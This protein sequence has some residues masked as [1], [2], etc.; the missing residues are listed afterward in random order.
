MFNNSKS[1]KSFQSQQSCIVVSH[2]KVKLV[3]AN[4]SIQKELKLS[5][6]SVNQ[7]D[8]DDECAK[9]N[10]DKLGIE[11]DEEIEEE[12]EEDDSFKKPFCQ[13]MEGWHH[14]QV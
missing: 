2:P 1:C 12:Q 5:Q 10:F 13:K 11:H 7:E 8:N 3:V 6:P 9:D 14:Q 4:E